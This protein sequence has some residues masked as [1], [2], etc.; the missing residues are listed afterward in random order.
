VAPQYYVFSGDPSLLSMMPKHTLPVF[1][2]GTAG[3]FRH[4]FDY[5][6]TAS[7]QPLARR[8]FALANIGFRVAD[9]IF[10]DRKIA[11][12]TIANSVRRERL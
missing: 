1:G 3:R 8:R 2:R 4:F 7:F 12:Y 6:F 10:V 11:A 9:Q 5:P